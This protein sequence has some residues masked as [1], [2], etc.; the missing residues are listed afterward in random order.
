ML[1]NILKGMKHTITC[2]QIFYPYNTPLTPGWGLK[3][4]TFF[5]PDSSH[6]AYQMN[7][8]GHAHTMHGHLYHGWG[9]GRYPLIRDSCIA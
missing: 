5:S 6:V 9:W 8:K 4:K 7:R 2:K 3:A 1:Y